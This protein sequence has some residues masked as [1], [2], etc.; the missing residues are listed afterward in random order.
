[1]DLLSIIISSFRYISF[2]SLITSSVVIV[3]WAI[4]SYKKLISQENKLSKSIYRPYSIYLVFLTLWILTNAYFQSDLLTIIS[5]EM[6]VFIARLSNL[7]AFFFSVFAFVFSYR[8]SKRNKCIKLK[9]WQLLFV[10]LSSL[11]SL[12]V[13]LFTNLT[14]KGINITKAGDFELMLGSHSYLFFII[15]CTLLVM[16]LKN[17]ILS[18]RSVLPLNRKKN[19]YMISG[20]AAFMLSTIFFNFIATFF[21]HDF[22]LTWLSPSFAIFE[23][24]LIG[25]ALINHRF[26]SSRHII[27][28][29]TSYLVNI[30][31]YLSPLLI[32]TS[33]D[34]N[35]IL[36]LWL[37]ITG[38]CWERSLNVIK[39]YI[40]Y[41]LYGDVNNTVNDI[42]KL[43]SEFK[44]SSGLALEKITVILNAKSGKIVKVGVEPYQ[45]VLIDYLESK[46]KVILKDE[47]DYFIEY[48]TSNIDKLIK[49]R[50]DMAENNYD[51]ILPIS[52]DNVI[53]HLF[54]ISKKN[55]DGIFSS[56]EI[57]ALQRVLAQSNKYIY[58]EEEIRKSQM[59]AG[60]IAHEMKTPLSKIQYHFERIDADLLDL[61]ASSIIPYASS[62]MKTLY[63]NMREVKNAVQLSSKF[64]EVILNELQ[65]GKI[66]PESFRLFSARELILQSLNDYAFESTASK[67]SISLESDCGFTF[68][69]S[70]TLYSFIIFNLLNNS[71]FYLPQH[72]EL[73]INISLRLG[74]KQNKVIFTD[75]GPGINAEHL[76]SIFDDMYTKGKSNG[77]GLGLSYCKR[78]M[79]AF[80][81]DITCRSELGKFTEFTLSFPALKSTDDKETI[82]RFKCALSG[83]YCLLVG[84]FSSNMT[85]TTLLHELDI[86]VIRVLNVKEMTHTL[87]CHHFDFIF[88]SE[89]IIQQSIKSIKS[90]RSGDLGSTHQA[91]PII[92][93]TQN[94]TEIQIENLTNNLIQGV[95]NTKDE[96]ILFCF[97]QLIEGGKLKPLGNL[98]GEKVLVVD[99][100]LV[101]RL[102][103]KHYLENE[104]IVFLQAENGKE[105]IDI[106][107]TEDVDFILMDIRMPVMDG[108]V[109]TKKIRKISPSIPIVALSGEYGKDEAATMKEMMEDHLMK[110]ITKQALLQKIN[111]HLQETPLSSH[112][113]DQSYSI[114]ETY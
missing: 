13:N 97:Q 106:V 15:C 84:D 35:V 12:I 111:Q 26:Y 53:T 87:L 7:S 94:D 22:S 75:T 29:S 105:A 32:I 21:Y 83:K 80:G 11:Y 9:S 107:K 46:N 20:V 50:C 114:T 34:H 66:S 72:P 28:V 51:L 40:S 108:F 92:I 42:H 8:I 101:N 110:P 49:I 1:M 109:A 79:K 63:E 30:S 48:Q 81:G 56:E 25:Y 98:I 65:G 43:V 78:V 103:I 93:Y 71:L 104:G 33:S 70:D 73:K 85:L 44:K 18:N 23:P 77:N 24:F 74:G 112:N 45:T 36:G 99:D 5:E 62:G 55:E 4:Y 54:M 61:N 16:T 91:T 82:H 17:F 86:K 88:V 90:I 102:L 58:A 41:L 47:L 67:N 60:S 96:E 69:G 57:N 39:T 27:Y 64:I 113:K 6:S 37:V 31:I 100:I 89:D 19:R 59:L 68:N 95:I 52:N 3:V 10:L 76:P 14:V 2:S 38:I